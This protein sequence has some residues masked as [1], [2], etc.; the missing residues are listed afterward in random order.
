MSSSDESF[1]EEDE[2]EDDALEGDAL[3]DDLSGYYNEE[4]IIL[5]SAYYFL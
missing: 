2:F 4:I 1:D 3:E 5:F